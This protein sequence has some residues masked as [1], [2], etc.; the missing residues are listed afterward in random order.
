MDSTEHEK[1]KQYAR[2]LLAEADNKNLWTTMGEYGR[3]LQE[4]QSVIGLILL[5]LLANN[6]T[7]WI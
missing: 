3:G 2:K 6:M 4:A 1:V 5:T 7:D